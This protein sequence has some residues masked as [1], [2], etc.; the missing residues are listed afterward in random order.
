MPL[1]AADTLTR[2]QAAPA[3]T[4]DSLVVTVNLKFAGRQYRAEDVVGALRTQY[5]ATKVSSPRDSIGYNQ[6]DLTIIP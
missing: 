4:S 3:V 2:A 5:G 6:L 1:N